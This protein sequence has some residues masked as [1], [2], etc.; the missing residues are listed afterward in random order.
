MWDGRSRHRWPHA[1]S[2]LTALLF[3]LAL[4]QPAWSGQRASVSDEPLP[5]DD[6]SLFGLL[7]QTPVVRAAPAQQERLPEAVVQEEPPPSGILMPIQK[8]S[9]PA[10]TA[11]A[12]RVEN[13]GV[14]RPDPPV[15]K[16]FANQ[17]E[18]AA[19]QSVIV[20]LN[21][22]A[23]RVSI[24]DPELADVVLVSPTEVLINGRGRRFTDKDGL[25]HIEEAQTSVVFWDKAGHPDVRDLLI[26]KSRLEQVEL[27]V[28]IAELNRT[29]L[30]QQGF[31]FRI[32]RRGV[33]LVG[34]GGKNL[35][36]DLLDP[37]PGGGTDLKSLDRLAFYVFDVNNNFDAF[38]ELLQDEGLGK[39]LARPTV[40][41]KSG[42][43]EHFRVG[44]EVGI[45]TVT[46]NTRGVEFKEFGAIVN[47]TATATDDGGVDLKVQ[48]E[49]SEPDLSTGN[50]FAFKSR[51]VKTRV[52]LKSNQ[53]LVVAGLLRDNVSETES[54]IPLFGDIPYF[55]ALFRHTLY[56]SEREELVIVVKPTIVG[57]DRDDTDLPLPTERGPLTRKEVRTKANPNEVSRPRLWPTL[58]DRFSTD[59]PN[60]APGK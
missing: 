51:E 14:P 53:S 39:I 45:P 60:T 27:A 7:D 58:R 15:V 49:L 28:T 38:I 32:T 21:R 2:R 8:T 16:N 18:V 22:P 59:E 50:E 52:R 48:A 20:Q 26:N 46:A 19:S 41:A 31:D 33:T 25:V 47:A 35:G 1:L 57:F 44:G 23:E 24:A 55:G 6:R 10:Q 11:P 29:A 12:P 34:R 9:V 17:I 13:G 42:E 43:P 37:A 30:E 5:G 3:G 4:L 40:L 56:S 36:R 54:K